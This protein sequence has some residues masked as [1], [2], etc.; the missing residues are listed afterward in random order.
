MNHI[1]SMLGVEDSTKQ[2]GCSLDLAHSLMFCLTCAIFK[3]ISTQ[4]C[5]F[6]KKM[7]CV[8]IKKKSS[9][10]LLL[11]KQNFRRHRAILLSDFC[12]RFG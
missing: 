8:H 11:T 10:W 6:K 12:Q 5:T 3:K 4:S 9:F 1:G 7:R 2:K